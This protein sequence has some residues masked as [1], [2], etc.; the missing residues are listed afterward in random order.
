MYGRK[1]CKFGAACRF[2]H[3]DEIEEMNKVNV[4]VM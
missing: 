3:D 2:L 1:Y 4:N